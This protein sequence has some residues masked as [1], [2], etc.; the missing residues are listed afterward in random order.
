MD[1]SGDGPGKASVVVVAGC[2]VLWPYVIPQEIHVKIHH[3]LLKKS[4]C[5][6]RMSLQNSIFSD[7]ANKVWDPKCSVDLL[8]AKV[9]G[10][11][12]E[13]VELVKQSSFITL[14]FSGGRRSQ[15][16]IQGVAK[17]QAEHSHKKM[18]IRVHVLMYKTISL[19]KH[20][21]GHCISIKSCLQVLAYSDRQ[22]VTFSGENYNT[23]VQDENNN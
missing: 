16:I 20:I 15:Q 22:L 14:P 5:L 4:I 6:P 1:E 2:S 8:Q 13:G 12:E 7:L 3:F 9:V 19:K 17:R 21:C 11:V 23:G 18:N 10:V